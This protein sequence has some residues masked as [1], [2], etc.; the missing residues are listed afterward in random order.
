MLFDENIRI[1]LPI[2][3]LACRFADLMIA[4][5]QQ[6][7]H[8]IAYWDDKVA[9]QCIDH[10]AAL[11]KG[12][13]RWNL[14]SGL[15]VWSC[16]RRSERCAASGK[17]VWKRKRVLTF[18]VLIQAVLQRKKRP[19]IKLHNTSC[20]KMIGIGICDIFMKNINNTYPIAIGIFLLWVRKNV[21]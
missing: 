7:N 20:I 21:C 10:P 2:F 11:L 6:R 15:L 4:F 12:V 1:M 3:I 16:K 18:K 14:I 19:N 17:Q 9:S 13:Y 5:V 8:N